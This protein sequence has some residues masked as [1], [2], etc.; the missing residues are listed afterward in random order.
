MAIWSILVP[1]VG[2]ASAFRL[3]KPHSVWARALL[4]AT[5][6]RNARRSAFAGSRG[7]PFWKRGGELLGRLR[8]ARAAP[9]EPENTSSSI[10]TPSEA[11]VGMAR[12]APSTPARFAPTITATIANRRVHLERAA[13]VEQRLDD[14]VLELLVDEED[15]Q[16]DDRVAGPS[17][18]QQHDEDARSRRSSGRSAG[19]GR[20][21]RPAP[22]AARR[23]GI[24]PPRGTP[25]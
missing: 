11:A 1:V 23:G 20:G 9:A 13:L 19:S 22:P 8:P 25:R 3:A 6:S 12:G 7:K 2:I 16:P 24:P 17:V 21:R 15:G 14:P 18:D 10:T 5:A 4:H